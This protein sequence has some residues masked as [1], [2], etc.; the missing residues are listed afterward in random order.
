TRLKKHPAMLKAVDQRIAQDEAG[1][2]AALVKAVRSEAEPLSRAARNAWTGTTGRPTAH[3]LHA[4]ARWLEGAG[5]QLST[6]ARVG[7][8]RAVREGHQRA[9]DVVALWAELLSDRQALGA[10]FQEHAPGEF[11]EAALDRAHK[12]CA[13][14]C[15]LA[16]L[17]SEEHQERGTEQRRP[18]KK[19][20]AP[21]PTHDRFE[22][23]GVDGRDRKSTRLNSSHVK[24]SYAVFCLK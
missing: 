19:S 9:G 13:A 18:S 22:H 12:W 14:R 5:R 2:E 16:M 15:T 3:R 4:L 24:I 17:E 11:S 23:A 20:R 1:V 6:D 8:E 10:I 7:I 21:E